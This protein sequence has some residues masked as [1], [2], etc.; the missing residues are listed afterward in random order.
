MIM[1]DEPAF[2]P[3]CLSCFVFSLLNSLKFT[4]EIIYGLRIIIELTH[5]QLFNNLARASWV[6][7]GKSSLSLR[8]LMVSPDPRKIPISWAAIIPTKY[9]V[10]IIL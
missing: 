10:L 5:W 4:S 7:G 1:R 9:D 8:K 6:L 3:V 2:R